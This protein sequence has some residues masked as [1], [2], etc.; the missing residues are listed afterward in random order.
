MNNYSTP[1][2]RDVIIATLGGALAA[3][4]AAP[5]ARSTGKVVSF[6]AGIHPISRDT[7]IRDTLLVSPGAR[8]NIAAGVTLTLLGDMVA[9]AERIFEGAGRV[10]LSRSRVLAARPEWW[11]AAANDPAIDNVPALDACLAAHPAMQLGL[12]DYHL[13]RT[14]VIGRSN[15]RIWGIGRTKD[16][17]G[18]RLLRHGSRGAVVM[19]GSGERPATINDYVRGIDLRWV[20]LGRTEAAAAM[21][22]SDATAAAGLVVRHVLDAYCEGL[23]ANEHAICYSVRGAVRSYFHDCVAF[24]SLARDSAGRDIFIGFDLD[25]RSPPIATGANASVY[26]ID[27]NAS[28]G[29][30][31]R[32]AQSIGCRL[33]GAMSD[34]SLIR[35]ETTSLDVGIDIDGKA[36][37]MPP[38]QQAIAHL[39]LTIDTPVLDQCRKIGF[40][41]TGMSGEAMVSVKSPYVGLS[42]GA[43]SAVEI[44]ESGG[45][46]G[47]EGGQVIGLFAPGAVGIG[48]DRVTGATIAGTRI[49]G[50]THP[51]RIA[52]A[53]AFELVVAIN[54]GGRSGNEP[55]IELTDCHAGYLRPRVAGPE[56]AYGV[57]VAIDERSRGITVETASLDVSLTNGKGVMRGAMP[58]AAVNGSSVSI[59]AT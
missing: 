27:C 58:V 56:R 29:N 55:A 54:S 25:G 30:S 1:S 47:I 41:L 26:L 49:L 2:R 7:V 19:L 12:G 39:D 9:A 34:T 16:A 48:I 46:I 22:G 6:S 59:A 32:L 11:G 35:F 20:E 23:R 28:T 3:S 14:W 37:R 13:H 10:D 18:T 51:V 38:E 50:F 24:R 15:R 42:R 57:A 52:N 5:S 21:S 4:P 33:L 53:R 40:R 36:A 44:T 43:T 31:P 8:F 45:S 17:Q